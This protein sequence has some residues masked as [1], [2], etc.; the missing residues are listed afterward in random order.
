VYNTRLMRE[1]G[2]RGWEVA[3]LALPAGFPRPD[4]VARAQSARLLAALPD[5][6]LV[7]A[8]QICFSPLADELA[9]EA[10]RLRLVMIFHHPIAM[11]EGL[12]P[13]E[14]ARFMAA[15]R[16]ALAC[17]RMVVASSR[18]TAGM[19]VADYH[20]PEGRIVVALPGIERFRVTEPPKEAI[21]RLLSVGAVIPR[22][23]YHD[24]IEALAG[25]AHAPW[26]LSIVG[27]LDRAPGYVARLRERVRAVRLDDKVNFRGG[28]PADELEAE[29]QSAQIYVAAS[30]HEGYGMAVAEAIARG[31]PTVTTGAD[32]VRDWL[33]PAAALI[34]PERSPEALRAALLRALTEPSLRSELRA[35]A[36]VQ[37]ARFPSW[38]EAGEIV[39]QRLS[40]I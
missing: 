13:D 2:A 23:G 15:E 7:A 6:A 12:P 40:E 20:V 26:S 19:L 35:A 4:A 32:A 33:D 1:L 34:V 14:R 25:L 8:D 11:E 22:K 17:C 27:D 21:P 3:P 39:D 31:L 24:L 5:G 29:W 10:Q 37:A 36:L 16:A 38:P 28:I 30:L 9:R 18:T